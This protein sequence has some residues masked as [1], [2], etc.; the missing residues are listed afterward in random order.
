MNKRE[1]VTAKLREITPNMRRICSLIE[2]IDYNWTEHYSKDKAEDMYQRTINMNIK[3]Q[4]EDIRK[5][6]LQAN[7]PVKDK[8][9]LFKNSAGRYELPSGNYFTSGGSLEFLL[10][11]PKGS[12]PDEWI[13]SS[14]EHNGEDY[15]LT[16]AKELPMEGLLVRVKDYEW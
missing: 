3:S 12:W 10:V 7:A 4:L 13:R 15:Y 14:V 8:G 11:D 5:L 1:E 9:R 2:E 16:E 6:I